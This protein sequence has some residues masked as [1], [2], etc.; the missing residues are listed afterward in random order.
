MGASR[1]VAGRSSGTVGSR[2]GFAPLSK[3]CTEICTAFENVSEVPDILLQ[4]RR[5]EP[6]PRR[7]CRCPGD[8]GPPRWLCR[9]FVA[10]SAG[11]RVDSTCRCTRLLG[12]SCASRHP[13]VI[14][15]SPAGPQARKPR[16]A[17]ARHPPTA[18][19][20]RRAARHATDRRAAR[21]AR[22]SG[23]GRLVQALGAGRED[24]AAILGDPDRML[25]LRRE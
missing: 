4:V 8:R 11:A 24:L 10:A 9:H 22:R 7:S 1:A 19:R 20:I 5:A 25:E 2:Q 15:I 18:R 17:R 21:P 23:I 6:R 13:A 12:S 3:H 14:P 16:A